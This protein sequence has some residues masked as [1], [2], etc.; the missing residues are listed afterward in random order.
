MTLAELIAALIELE[1]TYGGDVFVARSIRGEVF[2]LQG[3]ADIIDWAEERI[4][5]GVFKKGETVTRRLRIVGE[6]RDKNQQLKK[7][8]ARAIILF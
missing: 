2:Y 6:S 8:Q 4:V 3:T 1:K 5:K 7:G